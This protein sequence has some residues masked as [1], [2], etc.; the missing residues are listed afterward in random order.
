M[1]AAIVLMKAQGVSTAPAEYDYPEDYQ[2]PEPDAKRARLID[3]GDKATAAVAAYPDTDAQ[4]AGGGGGEGG[5]AAAAAAEAAPAAA[6]D[7]D[8]GGGDEGGD[9]DG[10]A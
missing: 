5:A 9:G 10:E 6:A 3:G 7:A 2:L 8:G 4:Y 1:D